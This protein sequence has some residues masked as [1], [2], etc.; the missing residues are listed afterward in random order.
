VSILKFVAHVEMF[1]FLFI[2]KVLANIHANG[3]PTRITQ[4]IVIHVI[5]I[6]KLDSKPATELYHYINICT[7][8]EY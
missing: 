3:N 2:L 5:A 8:V 1:V 6:A 4:T 7:F